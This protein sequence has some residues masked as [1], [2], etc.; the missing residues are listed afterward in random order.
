MTREWE[1][2]EDEEEEREW[3]AMLKLPAPFPVHSDGWILKASAQSQNSDLKLLAGE[4]L[5]W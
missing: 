3:G 1:A 5:A 4:F 2:A